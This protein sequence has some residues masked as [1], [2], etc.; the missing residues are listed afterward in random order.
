MFAKNAKGV[1]KSEE[2][3]VVKGM[4]R[5]SDGGELEPPL[6]AA[7]GITR[8]LRCKLL[9]DNGLVEVGDH[10]LILAEVRGVIESGRDGEG[11]CYSDGKYRGV[12]EVIEVGEKR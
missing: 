5:A 7:K 4:G 11:L 3:M 6:L 8:V 12:G 1:F 9:K 2:F 10:T